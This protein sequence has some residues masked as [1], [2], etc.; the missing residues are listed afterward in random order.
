M[1]A[2]MLTYLCACANT[3]SIARVH[4]EEVKGL[5]KCSE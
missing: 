2:L 4:P 1:A 3:N 5:P